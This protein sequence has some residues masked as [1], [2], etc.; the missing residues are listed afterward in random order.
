MNYRFLISIDVC[1]FCRVVSLLNPC[2]WGKDLG[3]HAEGTL[4]SVPAAP[5]G[6]AKLKA[7]PKSAPIPEPKAKVKAKANQVKKTLPKKAEKQK[8]PTPEQVEATEEPTER[9]ESDQKPKA[10]VM[11]RPSA[12]RNAVAAQRFFAAFV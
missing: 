3:P 12:L 2:S 8:Q 1:C 9:K 11:K 7:K 5:K 6:K 10:T 4:L